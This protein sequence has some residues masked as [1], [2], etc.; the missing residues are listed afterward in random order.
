MSYCCEA[1]LSQGFL[2]LLGRLL[3]SKPVFLLP[4]IYPNCLAQMLLVLTFLLQLD[5]DQG[6]I[7]QVTF[8]AKTCLPA[9][10]EESSTAPR[11]LPSLPLLHP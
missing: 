4:Y 9:W 7:G 11:S 8:T 2:S 5:L 6:D 10:H 1:S 3:K